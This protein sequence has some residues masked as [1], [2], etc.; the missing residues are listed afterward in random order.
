MSTSI[1]SILTNILNLSVPA[2]TF[3]GK[4][5]P[6]QE[7]EVCIRGTLLEAIYGSGEF[8][9][10]KAKRHH[11]VE[12]DV[13]NYKLECILASGIEFQGKQF[14]V[15]GAGSSLKDGKIW[16][17]TEVVKSRIHSYFNSSQEA[18]TYFGVFTSGCYHGIHEMEYDLRLVP[19][20]ELGTADQIRCRD[21]IDETG[22]ENC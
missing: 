2:F 18:L 4:E 19:D 20:G 10:L 13:F 6:N 22:R 12:R 5:H 11:E 15:L 8:A 9:I 16:L 1:K 21:P 14:K 3:D 7:G 17:G